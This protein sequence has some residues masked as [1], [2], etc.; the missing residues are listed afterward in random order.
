MNR[1]AGVEVV[2]TIAVLMMT[3]GGVTFS[4][5]LVHANMPPHCLIALRTIR[6]G[7]Q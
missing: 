2:S 6:S 1:A 3:V 7:V 4:M 5:A